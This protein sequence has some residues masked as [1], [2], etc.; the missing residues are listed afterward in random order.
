MVASGTK[1]EPP[2]VSAIR[3]I[4]L[5]NIRESN[6]NPRRVFDEAQIRELAAGCIGARGLRD[7]CA[8][9]L[10]PLGSRQ[11]PSIVPGLRLGREENE[12]VVGREYGQPRE[13]GG[14]SRLAPTQ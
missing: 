10:P 7:G 11:P 5:E 4:P 2:A 3:D 13:A 6:S 12:D 14:G 8:G 1:T 9:L